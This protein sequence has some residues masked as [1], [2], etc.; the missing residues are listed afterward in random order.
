MAETASVA[1][2]DK[3]AGPFSDDLVGRTVEYRYSTGNHYR[4]AFGSGQLTFLH[5]NAPEPHEP[6]PLAY[7]ARQ[8]RPGQ[9]LVHWVV[10][11]ANIHVAL[12]FDLD[13]GTVH[14]SALMPG[15]WEFVD[16]ARIVSIRSTESNRANSAD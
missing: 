9:Y 1:P 14:V 10:K 11:A 4:M 15:G 16:S 5:L 12:V 7:L 6:V 13:A 3:I 8:L 2:D